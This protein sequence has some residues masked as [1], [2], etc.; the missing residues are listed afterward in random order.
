MDKEKQ[1][2]D[3][4]INVRLT[5][6]EAVIVKK[7][8][9]ESGLQTAVYM[10]EVSLGKEITA[11]LSLDQVKEIRLAASVANNLN[12]VVKEMHLH[13]LEA[14]AKDLNKILNHLDKILNY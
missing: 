2:R 11:P 10:R 4:V 5:D 14:T 13:G 7:K 12:R 1:Y 3:N 9:F 6:E 8:A